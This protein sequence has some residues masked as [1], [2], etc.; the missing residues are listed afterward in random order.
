MGLAHMTDPQR[1]SIILADP[2]WNYSDKANAGKRGAAH[3]YPCL[4]FEHLVH[5][6]VE[7]RSVFELAAPDCVLFMWSTG[8]QEPVAIRLLEAWGFKFKTSA[9]FVWIK[10]G[11]P[12]TMKKTGIVKPGK[13]KWG[14]GHMTRANPENVIIGT[15]GKPKRISAGVHSVIEYPA[16]QHSAKP[17]ITRDRIVQLLGDV[18]RIELFA[19]EVV[20]G[21]QAWGLELNNGLRIARG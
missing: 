18:P 14:M 13:L 11:L 2:P 5:L 1:Y 19:R 21:W 10:R 7:G 15:R 12:K 16:T 20:P 3:K 8:P 6:K 9:G 17:P 4:S